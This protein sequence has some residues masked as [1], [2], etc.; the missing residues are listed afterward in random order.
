L[1]TGHSTVANDGRPMRRAEGMTSTPKSELRRSIG[2]P[3]ALPSLHLIG[4]SAFPISEPRTVTLR[5]TSEP[6][7]IVTVDWS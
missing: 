5:G 1:P 3:P 7:E 6:V 2:P 4:D